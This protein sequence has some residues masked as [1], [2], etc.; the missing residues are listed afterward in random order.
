MRGSCGSEWPLG[1]NTN[2]QAVGLENAKADVD[3][4]FRMVAVDPPSDTHS[5]GHYDWVL[6]Q[7]YHHDRNYCLTKNG[8]E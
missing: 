6:D 1:G 7:I 5:H 8:L 3:P 2:T 4:V